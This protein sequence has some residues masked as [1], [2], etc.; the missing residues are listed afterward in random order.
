MS[1][2]R[3]YMTKINRNLRRY[4]TSKNDNSKRSNDQTIL[5]RIFKSII[6]LISIDAYKICKF[7]KIFNKEDLQ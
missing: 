3:F 2:D 7:K 1:I 4:S 6:S 5:P